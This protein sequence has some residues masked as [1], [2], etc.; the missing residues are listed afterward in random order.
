MK[1]PSHQ[2]FSFIK[3]NLSAKNKD[4]S[5]SISVLILNKMAN[6]ENP[7]IIQLTRDIT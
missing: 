1:H 2:S 5:F 6:N 7:R 3:E 4:I